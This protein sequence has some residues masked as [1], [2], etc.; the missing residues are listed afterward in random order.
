MDQYASYDKFP[1]TQTMVQTKLADKLTNLKSREEIDQKDRNTNNPPP[2]LTLN[3]N[4]H[5]HLVSVSTNKHHH[6]MNVSLH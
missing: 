3:I 5:Q 6:L 1:V 4:K 2:L